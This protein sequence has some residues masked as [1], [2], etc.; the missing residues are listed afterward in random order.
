MLLLFTYPEYKHTYF[1]RMKNVY[2]FKKFEE[3]ALN[4]CKK[5]IK[6]ENKCPSSGCENGT[7]HPCGIA[8]SNAIKRLKVKCCV[9]NEE[10]EK[11]GFENHLSTHKIFC[12]GKE[13]GC[14]FSGNSGIISLHQKTC[15]HS[16]R[17]EKKQISLF[18]LE[19]IQIFQ[20]FLQIL[21]NLSF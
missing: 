14:K 18:L 5:C 15:E 20:Q 1:V 21:Q 17:Q 2:L 10:M 12:F 19:Q 13:E 3:C 6:D 4:F 8:I 9:C 16:L 7:V 11:S